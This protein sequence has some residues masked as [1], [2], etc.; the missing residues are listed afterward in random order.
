MAIP[1][2]IIKLLGNVPLNPT[3]EHTIDFKTKEEQY[4]YFTTFEKELLSNYTYV[5]K[6]REYIVAELPLNRLDDINYI[7]FR[8][9]P[10]DR[11]YYAFVTNKVYVNERSTQIF[12]EL[13]V[14]QTYMFD[15]V[16]KPSY[17]R[18]SHVDRWT[19]EHKPIYSKTDEGLDYG[20]EYIT[21][22]AFKIHQ[23]DNLR[24]LLVTMKE[25]TKI[26]DEGYAGS[27]NLKPVDSPF[28]FF[29]V[30]IPLNPNAQTVTVDGESGGMIMTT[31]NDLTAFMRSTA[32]GNYIVSISLL[33]YN[34]F[35][36]SVNVVGNVVRVTVDGGK[37][38]FARI[39]TGDVTMSNNILVLEETSLELLKNGYTL[40]ITDWNDGI[41]GSMPTVE[42]W[43]EIKQNPRKIQRDKRFESKLLSSPYRY[44]LL[45]DWRNPPTIFKNE[46]MTTDKIEIKYNFALSAQ[47]PFRYW[48]KDYKRDP[49]GRNTT[50]VQSISPDFPIISDAYYTY[51]LENKNT[52]QANLTNAWINAGSSMI[53]GAIS[54]AGIGGAA[55]AVYGGVTGAIGGAL[56]VQSHIRSENAKQADLKAVPDNVVNSNDSVFTILDNTDE[57]HFYR[58]RICCENEEIIGEIFHMSGYK[59]NR[60]DI[61][62][63]RSRVRFN[64]LQTVGAN[65]VGSFNQTALLKIKEIYDR[66]ITIWHYSEKD[67]YPLDYTYENIEV[68]LV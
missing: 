28:T 65:I 58:M 38:N 47:S 46:Y 63:T 36:T 44:N 31:Y 2:G 21:E 1:N 64:Y 52:I 20:T 49:V 5:R 11:W 37:F 61:P 32:I 14:M 67:F 34:P 6:E 9:S 12:F 18:Q 4:A 39:K 55:G 10:D 30:P 26:I 25:Y 27:S 62:N 45:T 53:S 22:T 60:V 68:N 51:M 48:I 42:Q 57:I 15:Y 40:A 24:W 43:N 19:A 13:D 56:N 35:V 16:W 41:D 29:L 59:V 33:T 54:G 7:L 3:Y 50:F 66:G 8:S 23:D 17:I